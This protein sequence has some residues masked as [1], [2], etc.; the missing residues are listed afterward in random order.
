MFDKAQA[1]RDFQTARDMEAELPP[2]SRAFMQLVNTRD[3]RTLGQRLLPYLDRWGQAEALSPVR[4]PAP[5][6]P[7]FVMHA[8]GDDVVPDSEATALGAYLKSQGTPVRVHVTSMIG[9]AEIAR[10][11]TI[12]ER[13]TMVRFWAELP[14]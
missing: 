1:A 5:R 10:T 13:V 7:V 6:P 2:E 14:W 8:A 12:G 3:V 11:P 9:H 4:S